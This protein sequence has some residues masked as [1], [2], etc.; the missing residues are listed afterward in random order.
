MPCI[1][2]EELQTILPD[3]LIR[4]IQRF[5]DRQVA[6]I[7]RQPDPDPEPVIWNILI[8]H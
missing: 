7:P 1:Y 3:V 4:L 5:D 2:L 8:V 6:V